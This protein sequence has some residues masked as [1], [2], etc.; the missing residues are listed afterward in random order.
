MFTILGI[1]LTLYNDPSGVQVFVQQVPPKEYSTIEECLADA[2]DI[3]R[4]AANPYVLYCTPQLD[5]ADMIDTSKSK[6]TPS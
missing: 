2:Y 6:G 1:L 3:N 4:D 5:D